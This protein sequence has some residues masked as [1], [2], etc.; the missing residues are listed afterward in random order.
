V[1]KSLVDF[2]VFPALLNSAG[3]RRW[4]PWG[5]GSSCRRGAR[6]LGGR[7]PGLGGSGQRRLWSLRHNRRC[8]V[9]MTLGV[10][11]RLRWL[12]EGQRIT[13]AEVAH[14]HSCQPQQHGRGDGRGPAVDEADVEPV[15]AA[16]LIATS[17]P[18]GNVIVVGARGSRSEQK[19]KYHIGTHYPNLKDT[20]EHK[21]FRCVWVR[22]I[23]ELRDESS[24][25]H[26]EPIIVACLLQSGQGPARGC[27]VAAGAVPPSSQLQRG[28][29]S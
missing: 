6:G 2:L 10:Q 7:A 15:A 27:G 19:D 4:A 12:I 14:R 24:T 23:T 1:G 29:L 11:L 17:R 18:Q 5:A 22:M 8:I 20:A 28:P 3:R 21:E 9:V 16:F 13:A 26:A 25:A